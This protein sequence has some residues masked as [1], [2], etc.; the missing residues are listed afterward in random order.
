MKKLFLV[1]V[2]TMMMTAL[3]AQ[4]GIGA[5]AGLLI[6][7]SKVDI[8][9][10]T[11]GGM[12]VGGGSSSA[13]QTGFYAGVFKEFPMGESFELE[14]GVNAVLVDG[15]FG[16]QIPIIAKYAVA[17]G[18]NVQAGPQVYFGFQET[19]ED[20]TNLNLGLAFGAGYDITEQILVEARYG[21]Q[22]NNY[23]TG[24]GS[25]DYSVKMNTLN[26]GVGYRF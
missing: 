19:G 9:A 20:Q 12:T 17:Q 16:L 25:S 7:M 13:S 11:I 2:A 22:L 1:A 14:P 6:G 21:L 15:N 26:I 18:F 3:N 4:S 8:P 10:V 24:E 23:Y 5:K